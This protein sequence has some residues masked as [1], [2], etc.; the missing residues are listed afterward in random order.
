MEDGY[1]LVEELKIGINNLDKEIED[2]ANAN[3]INN[4]KL[5]QVNNS[6][7][8]VN[9]V[10]KEIEKENIKTVCIRNLKI[11]G[12]FIMRLLPYTLIASGLFVAHM[13]LIKD[14][15]FYPQKVN[16]VAIHEIKVTKNNIDDKV[17]YYK[18]L[19]TVSRDEFQS[20]AYYTSSWQLQEDGKYHR[21][22]KEYTANNFETYE[23]QL[24]ANNPNTNLLSVLDKELSSKEEVKEAFELSDE[25]LSSGNTIKFV[26]RYKDD[27][28]FII[29]AQDTG[30]NLVY[31]LLYILTTLP[32][33]FAPFLDRIAK[34]Y[35][36][37]E[38]VKKK[39]KENKTIDISELKKLLD[40][41]KLKFEIVKHEQVSLIDPITHKKSLIKG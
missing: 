10:I 37:R 14:I 25:D 40:E 4:S 38:I 9:N 33:L 35:S 32:L 15:P 7:K 34:S 16:K 27:E 31:S 21:T 36:Y 8:N 41:K 1:N 23:Y 20:K 11:F 17:L 22:V 3:I 18:E 39:K 2:L 30:A 12:K 6:F 19:I 29:E 26:F 5:E 28:D 24:V 13:L